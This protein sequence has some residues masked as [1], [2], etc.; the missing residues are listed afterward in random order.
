MVVRTPSCT[1]RS[2]RSHGFAARAPPG[3]AHSCAFGSAP[4]LLGVTGSSTHLPASVREQ[5]QVS[6]G[7][8]APAPVCTANRSSG[9]SSTSH[10][11]WFCHHAAIYHGFI[12][13]RWRAQ[14]PST[15]LL[16]DLPDSRL[17]SAPRFPRVPRQPPL[18]PLVQTVLL[19]L[20]D[21]RLRVVRATGAPFGV[22]RSHEIKVPTKQAKKWPPGGTWPP[23]PA[24]HP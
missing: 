18:V 3:R 24:L 14:W 10:C 4:F 16:P 5:E 15:Q 7:S 19:L 12:S 21:S 20:L 13:P 11:C 22:S 2:W 23:T 6:T 17:L 8:P 9:R 1:L